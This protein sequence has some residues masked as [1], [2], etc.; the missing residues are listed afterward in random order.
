MSRFQ[1]RDGPDGSTV[2]EH[3]ADDTY[4]ALD[5]DAEHM[6]EDA[7]WLREQRANNK[8]LHW[9][10]RPSVVMLGVCIWLVAAAHTCGEGTRQALTFKLACNTI[11][12]GSGTCDST[13]TQLLVSKLQQFYAVCSGVITMFASGKVGPL[14]DQY[15]RKLFMLTVVVAM[16]SGKLSKFIVMESFS[17]LQF[18]SMVLTEVLQNIGGGVVCYVTLASC[19]VSDIAETHQ[20]TYFLGVNMAALFLGFSTGPLFGN[21]LLRLGKNESDGSANPAEAANTITPG[22]FLPLKGELCLYALLIVLLAF[23]LPESRSEKARQKSRSLSRSSSADQMTEDISLTTKSSNLLRHLNFLR[24]IRL[25]F[26]PKDSVPASRHQ[27]IRAYRTAVITLVF[28]ECILV[29]LVIPLGEIYILYGIWRF[30]WGAANIGHLLAAS[31][32]SRA[33]TLIVLSPIIHHKFFE[34]FLKLKVHHKYL[35][36]VDFGM[37]ASA[38]IIEIVAMVLLSMANSGVLFLVCLVF[39]SLATLAGPAMNSSIV[40][41]YPESRIG[42]VFGGMALIKNTLSI[43][44]PLSLLALYKFA[45]K[46]WSFP[47]VVFLFMAGCF[48]L[49]L[50]AV[51]YVKWVLYKEHKYL[52]LSGGSLTPTS[53]ASSLIGVPVNSDTDSGA[54]IQPPAPGTPPARKDSTSKRPSSPKPSRNASF[55]V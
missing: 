54:N 25:I 15:G 45:L 34:G 10:K 55:S 21:A 53:S 52:A 11:S 27:S 12:E 2:L 40:K 23:V 48:S 29:S 33:F 47:Q 1:G 17:E 39:S 44:M 50:I 43:I 51:C 49:F 41:F 36:D 28:V 6:D 18:T 42:E 26:Y 46:S 13:E 35:D 3:A 7:A 22:E 20:R 37:I 38:F 30:K 5:N 32:S 14:S 9:L 8:S 24:P 16:F 19:Y 4:T 31:S